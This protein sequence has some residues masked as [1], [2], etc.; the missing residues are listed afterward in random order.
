MY[1]HTCVGEMAVQV[2]V[3]SF[4]LSSFVCGHHVYCNV[5]TPPVIGKELTL[6]REPD[7]PVSKHAV[8]VTRDGQIVGH[9]SQKKIRE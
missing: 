7:N 4:E 5:L 2:S 1:L 8:G 9:I 6:K 3:G